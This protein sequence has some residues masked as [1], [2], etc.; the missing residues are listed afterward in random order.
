MKRLVLAL[1]LL[2]ALLPLSVHAQLQYFGYVGNADDDAGLNKTYAYTN[3]AHVSTGVDLYDPFVRNRVT[4]MSQKGLKATIDLGLVLWCDYD[5][6]GDGAGDGYRQLC[7][8]FVS[9]WNTWKQNNASVLTSD[10]VLA[11]SILDEPFARNASMQDFDYAAGMVKAAFPWVKIW[12]VEA[13]CIIQGTCGD[14]TPYYNYAGSLPSVDWIGLDAYGIHPATDSTFL[15]ARSALRSRFPTKKWLYVMDGYYDNSVQGYLGAPTV[16]GSIAR[17]WYDVARVDP[18][19]VTLGVFLWPDLP[20]TGTG[21]KNFQ[22]SVLAEHVSIGRAITQKTR[23]QASLPIGTYAVDSNGVVSGWVCDPD[24]ALCEKP[25]T[26]LYVDGVLTATFGLSGQSMTPQAQCGTGFGYTFQQTLARGT[27]GHNVTV[28]ATDLT[29]GSASIPSSCAQNPACVWTPHLSNFGYVGSGD[30]DLALNQVK[31]FTNY[32]YLSTV[33]D[34]NSTFVRDRV[35]AMSQKGLKATIDLGNVLWC[36]SSYTYLCSDYVA[37]WNAWKTTNASILAADKVLAFTIRDEPFHN[38][39]NIASYEVAAHMVKT[40]LPWSKIFLIEAACAVRGNCFGT[41]EP[42]FTQYAGT[43]PDVDWVGVDEYAIHPATNTGF[44][45][46]MQK[47][48]LKLPGK[49]TVYVMDAY[50]DAG[51]QAAIGPVSNMAALAREWYNVAHDDLSSVLFGA[52]LWPS[53]GSGV[54][55]SR[56]FACNVMQE[57]VS[58]G[59]EVTGKVR[60]QTGGPTGRLEGVYGGNV[61]GWACDAD[62]TVCENP[63]MTLQMGPYTYG[64][65]FPDRNDYVLSS[66]CGAG[67]GQRFRTNL[68][69]GSSGYSITAKAR[70]LDSTT[71]VTLPSNCLEN[72]A[73]LWY[74][75]SWEAKGYMEDL[76]VSGNAQGWVCDPDA[77]QVSTKVK[78]VAG[79]TVI[80]IYTADL[81]SEQA[82]ANECGGG[83]NHRFNVQLP[84]WTAGYAVQAYSVDLTGGDILIPWL[85]S[86]PWTDDWSCSW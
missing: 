69:S 48:K 24:A 66:Q 55:T 85:C 57:H 39:A 17:E 68:G 31:G 42:G 72:P 61:V 28:V 14:P 11:F 46:A 16:M 5:L 23:P 58:I 54:T 38:H 75:S 47:L 9:R 1:L 22:C 84:A 44:K 79:N 49:K 15:N 2:G 20:P 27:A 59:R 37:R 76:G 35:T 77:P 32:A 64:S 53:L 7:Y 19:A 4:A 10:K 25:A 12:M 36:G 80:G 62:G 30:D 60:A 83:N 45:S 18:N 26:N 70:D 8:D 74:S 3:F 43:M 51:H 29:S 34:V 65:S 56:N 13:A 6:D 21:S 63:A 50:W 41:S 52:F 67:L 73:C 40:D 86:D 71:T 82:V 78:L 81:S 33:A